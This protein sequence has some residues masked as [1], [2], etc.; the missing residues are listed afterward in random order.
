MQKFEYREIKDKVIWEE[1]ILSQ[2]PQTFLQSWNWG[3]VN[4]ETGEEITR[5]GF[6]KNKKLAGTALLIKQQAKRGSHILIPAG[7][8]IDWE[9]T[10]LRRFV[11]Q[12]IKE[13][14]KKREVWFV[15]IRPEILDNGRNRELFKEL[16]L[17]PS[18]MHL[19]AENTWVLDITKPEEELLKNMRKT[20]RYLIRKSLQEKDLKIKVSTNPKTANILFNLQ[21]ETAQRHGFVGF[22]KNLFEKEIEILGQDDQARVFMVKNKKEVLAIAIIVFYAKVAYYHFSASTSKL[23]KLPFSY[24]LQWEIIK[25]AKK[26]GQNRY[27]FWGI[28]PNDDPKHRFAGVTMFKKG[29]GGERVDWLHAHDLIVSPLYYFTYIF[30]TLRKITRKL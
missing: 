16:G 21:K 13:V 3:E 17:V 7:P 15:R 14:A 1:F 23:S 29:F 18:P 8:L 10:A 26:K 19:H 12:S 30:E 9:D 11:I 4:E 28:A 20:T 6:Y 25:Y 27:N 22:S 2:K 5:L 24:R